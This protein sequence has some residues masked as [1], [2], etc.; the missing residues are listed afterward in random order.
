MNKKYA[1]SALGYAI[2]G[3]IMIALAMIISTPMMINKY[4]EKPKQ[5]P[6][7]EISSSEMLEKIE[8]MES[9]LNS[10]I[11]NLEQPESNRYIC[12]IEGYIDEFGNTVSIEDNRD[13]EKF[14]FV[15]EYKD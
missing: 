11:D 12:K 9:R 10:K 6:V 7:I 1:I 4:K 2:V 3:V 15:C 5:E 14:V 13:Y 8:S